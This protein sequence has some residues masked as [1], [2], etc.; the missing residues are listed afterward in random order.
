MYPAILENSISAGVG[1]VD[2]PII[3]RRGIN[4]AVTLA[5]YRAIRSLKIVPDWILVDGFIIPDIPISQTA[6]QKGDSLSESIGAA[7]IIA[8]V[9]RDRVMEFYDCIYPEYGFAKNK[10]YGTTAHIEAIKKYGPCPIHR[11]TFA[12]INEIQ[13]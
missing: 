1:Y 5:M 13:G 2:P 8:K 7:S 12:P 9:L 11:K 4:F 10:G 3:D 6:L